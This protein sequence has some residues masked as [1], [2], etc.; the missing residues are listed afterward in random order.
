MYIYTCIFY[1]IN[2]LIKFQNFWPCNFCLFIYFLNIDKLLLN[3]V[4]IRNIYKDDNKRYYVL[5]N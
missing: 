1:I 2:K 3:S 4:N 5:L